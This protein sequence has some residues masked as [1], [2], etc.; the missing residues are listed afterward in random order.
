MSK[1]E[2]FKKKWNDFYEETQKEENKGKIDLRKKIVRYGLFHPSPDIDFFKYKKIYIDLDSLLS[3]VLKDDIELNK[4]T[5]NDLASYILEVF[6]DFFSFYKDTAQIYVIYNLAPN[7]SFMKIYPDW[8]KERYTRYEN[9]MV[10]DFIKKD[11]L[12]RLRKFS[13][14]VK[15]V[16]IIHAKDAVVLEVFKMVDYHN[17]AVNSIVISRDPHYLCVLAYYDINIYNGKNIIN[18]DTYKDEREYPKVHYSLIP[19][20]Y[21]ICGMKRNEYPGKNKF[22]PKKTDDYIEN[23]KSTIIDE[24]DFI[25]EDIIKYKNLFYLSNLLYNKEEGNDVREN[26][27]IKN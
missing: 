12:P 10:M 17:D 16:E 2:E 18:R 4:E 8:C 23:H 11:L 20:W 15:N 13:K 19:A 6:K 5:R 27:G 22:G 21:L 25:L 7:T 1:K 14:V 9:E 3:L 26:K 24:S